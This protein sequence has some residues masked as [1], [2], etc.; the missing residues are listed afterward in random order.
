[1]F[2]QLLAFIKLSNTKSKGVLETG[3]NGSVKEVMGTIYKE[4]RWGGKQHDFYS[5]IGSHASDIVSPYVSCVTDFFGSL[6]F[7]PSVCDLGCGDFNVGKQLIDHTSSYAGIDIVADLIVRNKEQFKSNHLEFYCLNI[8]DDKLPS[9]DCVLIRQVLQHLSN[10]DISKVLHKLDSYK[11]IILTEHVPKG[12]FT[13]NKDKRSGQGTRLAKSSGVVI[14]EPPFSRK[15][16]NTKELLRLSFG[17]KGSAI[18]T[19]LY[20]NH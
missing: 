7:K 5:G 8:V 11:Y 3:E 13:S 15:F 2:K 9:G 4:K 17:S 10:D 16:K 6:D 19:T 1:M 20:E 14:T 12:K 18:V